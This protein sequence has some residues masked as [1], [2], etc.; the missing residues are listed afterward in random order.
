MSENIKIKVIIGSTRPGRFSERPAQYIYEELGKV[1]GVEVELL[2]LRDYP[3][4]FYDALVPPARA[5]ASTIT[6]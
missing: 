5:G 4:P 3:M 1:P 2:D 6:P